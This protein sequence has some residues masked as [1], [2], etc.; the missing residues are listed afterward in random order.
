MRARQL[1]E[2]LDD[3]PGLPDQ[4]AHRHVGNAQAHRHLAALIAQPRELRLLP[5]VQFWVP[6]F[7]FI[8]ADTCTYIYMCVY[9][10]ILLA[11][12]PHHTGHFRIVTSPSCSPSPGCCACCLVCRV[13]GLGFGIWGFGFWVSGVGLEFRVQGFRVWGLG[14]GVQDFQVSG[15]GDSVRGLRFGV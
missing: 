1:H 7:R 9:I 11:L 2:L 3:A 4:P 14:I 13:W 12:K 10:Y 8:Y 5:G 6:G 15:F